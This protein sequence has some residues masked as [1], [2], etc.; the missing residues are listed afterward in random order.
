MTHTHLVAKGISHGS[1]KRLA[2]HSSHV[3]TS[4]NEASHSYLSQCSAAC[5]QQHQFHDSALRAEPCRRNARHSNARI[6]RNQSDCH[7]SSGINDFRLP[8]ISCDWTQLQSEDGTVDSEEEHNHALR[9]LPSRRGHG[10]PHSLDMGQYLTTRPTNPL[11]R[12]DS[13]A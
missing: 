9:F 13:E 8:T 4:R 2:S 12:T 5:E 11:V 1:R 7:R 10:V 3:D 6:D